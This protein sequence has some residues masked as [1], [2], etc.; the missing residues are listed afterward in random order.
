MVALRNALGAGSFAEGSGIKPFEAR[1]PF[2]YGKGASFVAA[3]IT[4]DSDPKWRMLWEKE[5]MES[6]NL[7]IRQKRR[8][9][10]PLPRGTHKFPRACPACPQR[11]RR[12]RGRRNTREASS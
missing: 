12:E 6:M 10:V 2:C 5:Y 8:L 1:G 3:D 7:N 11:G 9:Q 4:Y